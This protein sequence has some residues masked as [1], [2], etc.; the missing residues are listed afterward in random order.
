MK[1]CPD[2]NRQRPNNEFRKDRSRDDGL[3]A[4]CR[5]H[6][7]ER[8]RAQRAERKKHQPSGDALF[9][10]VNRTPRSDLETEL[11]NRRAYRE[12]REAEA[13]ATCAFGGCI[14]PLRYRS[15]YAPYCDRHGTADRRK[16]AS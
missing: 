9:Q 1:R 7:C 6:M 3:S 5:R 4:Y 10:T 12:R 16:E 13:K 14:T 15:A 11:A 2:C 8:Q